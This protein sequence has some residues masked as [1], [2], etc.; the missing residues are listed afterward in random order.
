MAALGSSDGLHGP[1]ISG[2]SYGSNAAQMHNVALLGPGMTRTADLNA[3]S[4]G[5]WLVRDAVLTHQRA[6]MSM[7]FDVKEVLHPGA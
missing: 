7:F 4:F 6:G 5:K 3:T 1:L 2:Y